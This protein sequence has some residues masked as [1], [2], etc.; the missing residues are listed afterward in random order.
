MDIDA[1]ITQAN[2]RLKK[3]KSG[4][5]IERRGGVLWIRGTLPSKPHLN[6]AKPYQQH[7]TLDLPANPVGIQQA[8]RQAKLIG[9]ELKLGRFDWSNYLSRAA[10]SETVSDW[11]VKFE[12]DYW[13]RRARTKSSE[14]TWKSNYL[15]VL[16]K[17]PQGEVLTLELLIEFI[18]KIEPDTRSRQRACTVLH[19]F[20][21]HAK[22][23]GFESIKELVG[24][25]SPKSVSPRSL[26]SDTEIALWRETIK[27]EG[28]RWV[29]GMVAAYGLRPH[30]VFH[31]DLYDF[32]TVRIDDDTKTNARFIYPIYPEWVEQWDLRNVR[33]PQL[34]V[35][36]EGDNTK[37][38]TKVSKFFYL[39][40][41]PFAAYDLRHSYAR[42]CS[43]FGFSPDLGA[44]LMGHSV[45]THTK[46][47]RAWID[48]AVYRKA[49]EAIINRAERPKPP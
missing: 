12:V 3:G 25:Y 19:Q 8:E 41:I 42:R 28:W 44:K 46:I 13:K 10:Q 16:S 26:P 33:L 43:E 23:P 40:D 5:S 30:E 22:L 17:L 7:F 18:L 48:E 32:P 38:G 35:I 4:V 31:V 9:A 39:S 45:S 20:A 21:K 49:Y 14:S 36:K 24:D 27:N 29:Y 34:K 1:H 47:Y 2:Q 6:R 15:K 37:I 11:I